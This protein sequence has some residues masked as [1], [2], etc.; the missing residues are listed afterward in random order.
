MRVAKSHPQLGWLKLEGRDY[1]ATMDRLITERDNDPDQQ[2][3][4]P[5][6]GFIDWMWREQLPALA[7]QDRYRGQIQQ[8]CEQLRRRSEA[9]GSEVHSLV[10]SK[11]AEQAAAEELC[12]QLSALLDE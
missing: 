2:R 8:H 10:G 5:A 4:G 1:S 3:A 12:A 9:I 6:P 11:L 7:R